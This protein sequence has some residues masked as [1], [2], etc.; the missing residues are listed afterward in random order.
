MYI[1]KHTGQHVEDN[2]ESYCADCEKYR[3][4]NLSIFEIYKEINADRH[5]KWSE[6]DQNTTLTDLIEGID[7]FM[8]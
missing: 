5:D 7:E 6:Y 8:L 3:I 2:G 4:Y 1:E